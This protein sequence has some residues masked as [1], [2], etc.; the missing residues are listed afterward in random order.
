MDTAGR[1]AHVLR[2]QPGDMT[3][4]T[5]QELFRKI[6]QDP[7]GRARCSHCAAHGKLRVCGG[8]RA[9]RRA[10]ATRP[11]RY[12][13]KA[14]ARADWPRHKQACGKQEAPGAGGDRTRISASERALLHEA[15]AA[16]ER[17]EE[18]KKM[19][20]RR[21]KER[22]EKGRRKERKKR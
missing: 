13:D 2:E 14:C 12:C 1:E 5:F 3:P 22:K 10:T 17:G 8:T 19:K 21:R 15:V 4:A 11:A 6:E 9:A 7:A 16:V 20:K 18:E